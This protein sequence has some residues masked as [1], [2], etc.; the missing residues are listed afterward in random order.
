MTPT[1][2]REA[3]W[4]CQCGIHNLKNTPTCGTCGKPRQGTGNRQEGG[5]TGNGGSLDGGKAKPP[6]KGKEPNKTE[7]HY[8]KWALDGKGNYE[9][10]TLLLA[11]GHRY[12]A[13]WQTVRPTGRLHLHETK[14]A[15]KHASHGRSRLAFD[16]ARTEH[17][18]IMFS[19]AVKTKGG[20]WQIET[21]NQEYNP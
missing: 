4:E 3:V 11:N 9:A 13:D 18:E 1:I 21:Y 15:Y 2:T 20:E 12:T 5:L 7:A 8:G 17:P 10:V 6:K 16:Q 14:G 19:W